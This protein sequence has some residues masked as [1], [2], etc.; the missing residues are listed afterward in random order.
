MC[1]EADV[2]DR[3]VAEVV[4]AGIE[5]VKVEHERRIRSAPKCGFCEELPAMIVNGMVAKYCHR[6]WQEV[7]TPGQAVLRINIVQYL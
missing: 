7:S 3:Y 4:N 5:K 2:S 6:C 1:D